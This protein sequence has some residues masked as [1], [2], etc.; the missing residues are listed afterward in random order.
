VLK[1]YVEKVDLAWVSV[2]S[3]IAE[4]EEKTD[5]LIDT[6]DAISVSSELLEINN[7][8]LSQLLEDLE[9]TKVKIERI[10]NQYKLI[11][12]L[13]SGQDFLDYTDE[14]NN[15]FLTELDF[16]N[17]RVEQLI[18]AEEDLSAIEEQMETGLL[19]LSRDLFAFEQILFSDDVQD[20]MVPYIEYSE[21][22]VIYIS[23][24]QEEIGQEIILVSALIE[25][26]DQASEQENVN[27]KAWNELISEGTSYLLLRDYMTLETLPVFPVG[28]RSDFIPGSNS[29][30]LTNQTCGGY[31]VTSPISGRIVQSNLNQPIEI[32]CPKLSDFDKKFIDQM[33]QNWRRHVH[34]WN[35]D[36]IEG[37]RDIWK[38]YIQATHESG[39]PLSYLEDE[40]N[41][42][43]DY[44]N[45]KMNEELDQD[46]EDLQDEISD[47]YKKENEKISKEYNLTITAAHQMFVVG[48]P[49][50]KIEVSGSEALIL[51]PWKGIFGFG[52]F[53]MKANWPI[54][55]GAYM[56]RGDTI[57]VIIRG[58]C[59]DDIFFIIIINEAGGAV[60]QGTL[61]HPFGSDP[62][63]VERWIRSATD[64]YE[65][66]YIFSGSGEAPPVTLSASG[67]YPDLGGT[68]S[69]ALEVNH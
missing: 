4:E 27:E 14:L 45:K 35:K 38:D 19:G 28:E 33:N 15:I 64:A 2:Q 32:T 49:N 16:H 7:E 18:D 50:Y 53:P 26:K 54:G 5:H 52:H 21:A 61:I 68:V 25:I 46:W 66:K 44:F 62:M 58:R 11:A 42:S 69:W 40:Y 29:T 12:P 47:M 10:Q 8:D 55:S 48:Y 37:Q 13:R 57:S 30:E 6:V 31:K 1:S 36:L 34:E 60:A 17:N 41:A 59:S 39:R 65:I 24:L 23:L 22:M 43:V 20:F 9:T 63:K 67:L 51:D 56:F 3:E